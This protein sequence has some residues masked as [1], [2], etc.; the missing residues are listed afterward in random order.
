MSIEKNSSAGNADAALFCSVKMHGIRINRSTMRNALS[1]VDMLVRK[2]AHNFVCF[3]EAN[4]FS[5]ALVEWNVRAAINQ[6]SLVYPDGIAPA[7]CAKLCTDIDFPRI[8]GPTFLLKVCEY[9]LDKNWRHFFLGG[10]EGVAERLAENL[11]KQFPG[12]QIAGTYCPPFRPLTTAE[13][14]EVKNRIESGHTDLLWVG[15]GGPKQEFWMLAHQGQIDVPV[16]LGVGAAFD[17]HSGNRPWAP[18]IVRR[19]GLEWLWRMFSGGRKTFLRNVKCVS[20][21]SL[22]LAKDVVRYYVLRRK[23]L[24]LQTRESSIA[25]E[26][27]K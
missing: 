10:A 9:G 5:R 13:E 23:R 24:P 16:M 3:Y 6:A 4:L 22:V 27:A 1:E 11:K 2:R 19:L 7:L 8:S 21:I 15:L 17:F 20:H 25:A 26:S 12:L 18:K 14:R